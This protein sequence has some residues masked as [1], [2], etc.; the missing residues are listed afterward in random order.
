MQAHSLGLPAYAPSFQMEK[1]DT[2]SFSYFLCFR[3]L[4]SG[5]QAPTLYF[6]VTKHTEA[7]VEPGEVNGLIHH[8]G[9]GLSSL[10]LGISLSELKE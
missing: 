8:S 10:H 2:F 4:G 5:V 9:L 1:N 3:I 6:G 7:C